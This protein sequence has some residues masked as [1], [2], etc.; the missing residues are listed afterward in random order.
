VCVLSLRLMTSQFRGVCD[1]II[2]HL[3]ARTSSG[4][5]T[6]TVPPITAAPL[7]LHAG[8]DSPVSMDSST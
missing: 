7:D 4:P 5:P 2:P 1:Y 8:S 3:D 6:L